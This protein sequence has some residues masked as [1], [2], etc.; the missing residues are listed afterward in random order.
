MPDRIAGSIWHQRERNDQS[1]MNRC[2]PKQSAPSRGPRSDD[3]VAQHDKI[4]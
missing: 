4:L 1:D 2:R 3:L